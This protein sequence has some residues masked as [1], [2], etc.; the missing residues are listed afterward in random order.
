MVLGCIFLMALNAYRH[1]GH[2]C[3]SEPLET[4]VMSSTD[5]NYI[6]DECA[7]E[8][9]FPIEWVCESAPRSRSKAPLCSLQIPTC[10]QLG[11]VPTG[12]PTSIFTSI[13]RLFLPFLEHRWTPVILFL[14]AS[15]QAYAYNISSGIARNQR[16][17]IALS[18]FRMWNS[19]KTLWI[20]RIV[21]FY[22]IL[23]FID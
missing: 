13:T 3:S 5:M 19:F 7:F 1:P 22:F 17:L 2:P 14:D 8:G 21:H 16:W 23:F 4:N 11:M 12:G 20:I 10:S 18:Y 6:A 9:K 15:T